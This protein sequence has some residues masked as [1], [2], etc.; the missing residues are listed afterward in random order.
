M[1]VRSGTGRLKSETIT[2]IIIGEKL[3]LVLSW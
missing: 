3:E 1:M 2:L